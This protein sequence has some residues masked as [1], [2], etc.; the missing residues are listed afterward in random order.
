MKRHFLCLILAAALM[1]LPAAA[2]PG[3][4][5]P[6]ASARPALQPPRP[7]YTVIDLGGCEALAI[8]NNGKVAGQ[9]GS[10]ILDIQYGGRVNSN[11]AYVSWGVLSEDS[12]VTITGKLT[13]SPSG[14]L[15]IPLIGK[16][17]GQCGSLAVSGATVLDGVLALDFQQGY[18]PR[19]GDRFTFLDGA[20]AVT[21][22]FDSVAISGLAPGFQYELTNS[23][24][25][26]TLRALNNGIPTSG[27]P[28]RVFLPL[29][30]QR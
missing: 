4:L 19:Q 5:T 2:F 30:R 28:W 3:P 25:E 27:Q 29:A 16:N 23:G 15:A 24:G 9:C 26:L 8:S 22:A 11:D 12:Q 21:G 1:L 20:G 13:M 18:A 17:A 10:G 7:R 6:A 14:R